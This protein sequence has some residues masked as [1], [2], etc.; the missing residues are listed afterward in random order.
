MKLQNK[1]LYSIGFCAL[2]LFSCEDPLEKIQLDVIGEDKVWADEALVVSYMANVYS[3]AEFQLENLGTNSNRM[4]A[5]ID[6]GGEGLAK[7]WPTIS[8][9]D[10]TMTDLGVPGII[11]YWDWTK[12][13]T[14]NEAIKKLSNPESSLP[15][16]YRNTTLGEAYYI[17]AWMYFSMAKRYGGLPI[18]KEPQDVSL[19]Y[20][21]LQVAR[22]TEE[23]TYDFIAEDL[24][25][26]V[27]LLD[28]KIQDWGKATK[29]A[30]LALKSRAMLYAGSIGEFGT[31]QANG[32]VGI[33]NADKYW[34][35]SL[36]AS[37]QIIQSGEF[38]LYDDAPGGTHAEKIASYE[39]MT[40]IDDPSSNKELIFTER[41]NGAGG[42]GSSID[43]YL[44]P[45]T[46][47][48]GSWG[49]NSQ[50]YLEF[51]EEYERADGSSGTI[52]RSKLVAG[53]RLTLDEVLGVKD[54][55]YYASFAYQGSDFGGVPVYVHEGTYRGGILG[56]GG[57]SANGIP[58]IGSSKNFSRTG[59]MN[60]KGITRAVA[61]QRWE[62][63]NDWIVFRLGEIYLN[64]AE[65][66]LGLGTNLSDGLNKL[67][68][69]RERAGMPTKTAL[70]WPTLKHERAIELA[71]E[72]HRYWD[73]RRWRDAVG[74]LT[75]ISDGGSSTFTGLH[76]YYD[77]DADKYEI[78]I[79]NETER[80]E[81]TVGFRRFYEKH[82]YFPINSSIL[83]ENPV[84]VQNPGY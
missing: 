52:D 53:N 61:A 25:M 36:E 39:N 43:L 70:D 40:L 83:A 60:I 26:A 13:R 63:T 12:I 41:Y 15:S 80:P 30:A 27:S 23:E 11:D 67:N 24:D 77:E 9:I 46:E 37:T 34:N 78:I 33:S 21:E 55:R 6:A 59:F 14:V 3:I 75:D 47:K 10:G 84:L 64:Y 48:D 65:A 22:S 57:I 58:G 7:N 19:S 18:I 81:P 74:V 72:N 62:G 79:A 20:E 51:V 5:V 71:F 29:W 4:H 16:D 49:S 45:V 66:Q 42:K 56:T 2:F 17:R 68:A 32:L 73:L 82:Y 38:E 31:V 69:I 8:L 50:V 35:L 28:G 54:P 44:H 1:I 76:Q